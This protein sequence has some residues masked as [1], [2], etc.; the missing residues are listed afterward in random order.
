SSS[1]SVKPRRFL[2]MAGPV[3][4]ANKTA[5]GKQLARRALL[6][7]HPLRFARFFVVSGVFA[8]SF[9]VKP[10]AGA[11][12]MSA[13]VGIETCSGCRTRASAL[14]LDSRQ[15]PHDRSCCETR[16]MPQ[17]PTATLR[18]NHTGRRTQARS[19]KETSQSN[20]RKFFYSLSLC[21]QKLL[22]MS[23]E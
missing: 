18:Q 22:A 2:D 7:R 13:R 3:C 9:V 21:N 6:A 17:N 10:C 11:D 23:R 4:G 14:A 5:W 1:M 8:R 16:Q 15:E 20:R 12:K 19:A